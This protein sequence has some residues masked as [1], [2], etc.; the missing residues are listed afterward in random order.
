MVMR[1][2]A[3]RQAEM[4]RAFVPMALGWIRTALGGPD[5]PFTVEESVPL[6]VD[7]LLSR[8]GMPGLVYLDRSG[9]TVSW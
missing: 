6:L 8:L 3:T 1:S 9:R 4:Q 5:A 7:V 2:F